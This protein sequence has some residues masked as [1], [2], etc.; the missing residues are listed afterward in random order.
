MR[1]GWKVI[2]AAALVNVV[3]P[4]LPAA[5]FL[6]AKLPG[7]STRT[8]LRLAEVRKR[9]DKRQ[10]PEAI[11]AIQHIL[12]E[13]GDDLAAIDPQQPRHL[14]QARR[15]CHRYL[16]SLPAEGLRLYR[17]HVDKEAGK[18][19]Q[20]GLTGRD[21]EVLKK[22][23]A[24]YFCSR[25][26]DRALD[27]LGDL[28]F[29]RGDFADAARWW[30][31]LIRPASALKTKGS[32]EFLR[33]PDTQLE[34]AILR[35]KLILAK[36]FQGE[37]AAA[38]QELKAYAALHGKVKGQ[39]AGRTGNLVEI[40]QAVVERKNLVPPGDE[41]AWPT[42]A[43]AAS[44]NRLAAEAP[45]CR[46]LEEPWHVSLEL[47]PQPA[48]KEGPQQPLTASEA[49]QAMAF[50]PIIVG[51]KVVVSNGRS[52]VCCDLFTGNVW[53]QLNLAQ[54]AREAQAA[55][56]LPVSHP[57]SYTLTAAGNQVFVR[58][59][60]DVLG[61]PEDRRLPH[62]QWHVKTVLLCAGL[63]SGPGRPFQVQWQ[64]DGRGK[65]K[66]IA[67]FEGSPVVRDGRVMIAR[68]AFTGDHSTTAVECYAADS[69]TLR[70][71]QEVC[72]TLNQRDNSKRYRH[73]LLTL[74][75][76]SVIYCSHD[77]AVVSLDPATGTRQWAVRYPRHKAP[78][79][80]A[81]MPPRDLAPPVS[82]GDKLFIAPA[83]F[84]RILCL[85]LATG[86]N[87]WESQPIAVRQLLGVAGDKLIVTTA[88]SPRGI[89]ALDA[90]TGICLR[91]WLQPDDGSDL[92][93]V[94]RGLLAGGK[95]YWPTLGGLV[96]LN[97]EDGRPSLTEAMALDKVPAGNL[98]LARGCLVIATD[99][100]LLG[101]VPPAH[102]LVERRKD[103][104][105]RPDAA[106]PHF[107]LA[108]AE[109]AT[110]RQ[111]AL[112]ELASA[113]KLA[114]AE[115]RWRH[116]PLREQI[117]S[118]KKELLLEQAASAAAAQQWNQASGFLQAA[119]GREFPVDSRLEALAR[120]A[121]VHA[122]AGQV[123]KALAAWQG[124]LADPAL[125]LGSL[126]DSTSLRQPAA[127]WA[128]QAIDALIRQH[129]RNHYAGIEAQAR[130]LQTSGASD[131]EMLVRRLA[132]QYPNA[133]VTRALVENHVGRAQQAR[134][135]AAVA[136]WNRFLLAG[137]LDDR[138]RA[139]SLVQ[140]ASANEG[141]QSWQAARAAWQR[142][143]AAYPKQIMPELSQTVPVQQYVAR[144][145]HSSP[146]LGTSQ[147]SP[148]DLALPLR[149]AWEATND[150]KSAA[151]A[152]ED[153]KACMVLRQGESL[154]C[155]VAATGKL[156]WRFRFSTDQPATWINQHGDIALAGGPAGVTALDLMDGSVLWQFASPGK[157]NAFALADGRVYFLEQGSRLVALDAETGG[158]L[159]SRW[160]PGA[161]LDLQT[162]AGFTRH[163]HAA[164]NRLLVQ[165]VSGR[166]W[167][168]DGRTGKR[169]DDQPTAWQPW[170]QPPLNGA[171]GKLIVTDAGKLT[172]LDS[173][174]GKEVG[175]QPL[176]DVTT[177]TGEAV[178]V[179]RASDHY[180]VLVPRN[181]H[182]DL[183]MREIGTGKRVWCKPLSLEEGKV[184]LADGAVDPQVLYLPGKQTI[185]AI[186]LRDGLPLWKQSLPAAGHWQAWVTRRFL[187]VYPL[188]A[189]VDRQQPLAPPGLD[190]VRRSNPPHPFAPSLDLRQ[191][192]M[193]STGSTSQASL[194]LL[195][196]PTG[197]LLQRLNFDGR[198]PDFSIGFKGKRLAFAL[199]GAA[200]GLE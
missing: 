65:N 151:T 144:K 37:R 57:L 88:A 157:A 98:A 8:T 139:R 54:N 173:S 110:D 70:W 3:I 192:V 163:F 91:D 62:M 189:Q 31:L 141:L 191:Q 135:H 106:L 150:N 21:P 182:H 197:R 90:S 184:C 42:F 6:P 101:Y 195:D 128:R 172:F 23:V 176:E 59:G 38:L 199:N 35:G 45:R 126:R 27:A 104:Q 4:G 78:S 18:L 15:L 72:E 165:T 133:A 76:S 77:G 97:Q 60:A 52:V 93:P 83:D 132:E 67:I 130:N 17:N 25:P 129:G 40:L 181:T 186:R 194:L 161:L 95:V 96:V 53:G 175:S 13:A 61:F 113:A 11:E 125:R 85:D 10:W 100:E 99:R 63:P 43:G 164:G 84:N 142:L 9:I 20:Q 153:P 19:L 166:R 188:Q 71:R 178:Q 123:D 87:I 152:R 26:G 185:Q 92:A 187:L 109:A 159:W 22:L 86:R 46:W 154:V 79:Q 193:T 36:V 39:L 114:S 140:L 124:I 80:E 177:L 68:T 44:R 120:L 171:E 168:L 64:V 34:P 127:R 158:E 47:E 149:R 81:D 74:A 122:R 48:R 111:G 147:D 66:Q 167:L 116:A 50:Y 196:L 169:I 32:A 179:R 28:A 105:A 94:G 138:Q 118:F 115:D 24:E 7:E 131:Q 162:N 103:A 190:L 156:I 89:R 41:N 102:R 14:L 33:F 112:K 51:D 30:R 73:H 5:E 137:D 146:Y 82:V 56:R 200:W 143:A 107:R 180:L 108:L 69:G 16:A 75:G 1:P 134:Y 174:T 136:R 2:L 55:A 148:L 29:E 117:S 119:A 121:D 198:G 145:L 49:A 155:R 58:L 160:G 12:E 183:E 170:A